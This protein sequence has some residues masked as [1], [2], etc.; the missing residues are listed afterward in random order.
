MKRSK[1]TLFE[2]SLFT[3]DP[4]DYRFR[5]VTDRRIVGSRTAALLC[6]KSLLKP[7]AVV[8][9]RYNYHRDMQ[10]SAF[11]SIHKGFREPGQRKRHFLML[12]HERHHA[13]PE[14]IEVPSVGELGWTP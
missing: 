2:V 10:R 5:I 3:K 9:T 11:C 4:N 8:T 7:H 13:D 14:C 12:D 1:A 6:A